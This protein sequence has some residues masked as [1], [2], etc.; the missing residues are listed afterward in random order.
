MKT[1]NIVESKRLMEKYG[2]KFADSRLAK[3]TEEAMILANSIGYPVALKVV[4]D[5]I[6]HKTDVGGVS[7]GIR[8]DSELERAFKDMTMSVKKKYPKA[9]L[10][11]VMVQKM[12]ED[13]LNILI[14]GKRDPQFGQVVVF[15]LGGIFVEVM[16]DVA[17]RVVPVGRKEAMDMMAETKAFKVIDGYRG[18]SYDAEALAQI[19]VKVSSMLEKRG[20][21][22]EMDIN[23]VIALKKGA[24][25]VDARIVLD[26]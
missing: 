25:A 10:R 15:G 4:S 14:G 19:I 6:S 16:E 3:S 26:G 20:D 8:G 21:I 5:D 23:P 1:L 13:G 18:K 9:K 12:V 7:V 22:V 24:V 11:G 2:I 17:M